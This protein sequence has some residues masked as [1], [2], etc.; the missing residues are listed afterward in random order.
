MRIQARRTKRTKLGL[1]I[2]GVTLLAALAPTA[3]TASHVANTR[4]PAAKS[5]LNIEQINLQ[6]IPG[7]WDDSGGLQAYFDYVNAHGGVDGHKINVTEC[8][9]GTLIA[10]SP[11]Q[12]T[13]CAQQ[14]VSNHVLA[15]VGSFNDYDTNI[16]PIVSPSHIADFGNFPASQV[17]S[18]DPDSYP[19]LVPGVIFDAGLGAMLVQQGKCK[20][21][22][23]IAV[24][25]TA[26]EVQATNA[27]NAGTRWAGGKV[28]PAVLVAATETDF[29][30]AV[31][32]LE[33]EGATCIAD[34]TSGTSSVSLVTA[35]SQ[36]GQTLKIAGIGPTFSP[37]TI[38]AL[39]PLANGLYIDQTAQELAQVTDAGYHTPQEKTFDQLMQQYEPSD[40]PLGNSEWPCYESA[41][42]FVIVAKY[43]A[44][45]GIAFTPSNFEKAI[46][47]VNLAT[48]FFAPVD[49]AHK[50]PV[51]GY[52]RIHAV[53]LNY[54][55]VQNDQIVPISHRNINVA[56]ALIKYPNG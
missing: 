23:V 37:A 1:V 41:A 2:A 47:K 55:I 46:P 25:G 28:V 45:N 36:S 7:V 13:T 27:T 52:P 20:S 43:M 44:Q 8:Y 30:P 9:A 21:V 18:T 16:L 35:V 42:A 22:G 5:T 50:G 29:A 54:L 56:E 33:S 51:P 19:L 39:G 11:N 31:A 48:G 12:A 6:S 38:S 40:I 3:A 14:A 26:T 15:L 17:D 4:S 24:S 53:S 10:S 49:F 32:T 34:E